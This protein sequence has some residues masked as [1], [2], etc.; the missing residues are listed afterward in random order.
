MTNTTDAFTARLRELGAEGEVVEFSAE[1]PTA[2]AAAEELGCAVGAI[3]NSLVFTADGEPLLVV[4]SGAHRVDTRGLERSLG[5]RKI[6][7]ASPEF[8]L[9]ATGQP[10]GGVGPVGHPQPI[11]TVVDEALGAHP[12]V[13]AGAGSKHAMFPTSFAELL[14]ITGGSASAVAQS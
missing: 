12:T 11:R 4:A 10:V 14:R 8:V 1:V 13:W 5:I 9:E 7:R 2:A 3:A 6:R